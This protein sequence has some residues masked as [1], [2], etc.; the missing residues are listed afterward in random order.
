MIRQEI[1]DYPV[2]FTAFLQ[3]HISYRK[4]ALIEEKLKRRTRYLTVV[5][6]DIHKSHN[7]SA[8]LRTSECFGIQDLHIIEKEHAYNLHP[9]ISSGS[10]RWLDL[11]HYNQPGTNNTEV[12]LSG[13]KAQGYR[14]LV[15]TL[16]DQA[17]PFDEIEIDCKSA[18]VFGTEYSGVSDEA[19][20]MADEVIHIPMVGFTE[21]LNL[22]VSAGIILQ[23]YRR[24]LDNLKLPW[25]LSEKE[26]E[27]I[28]LNWTM[29]AVRKIDLHIKH[30]LEEK[31]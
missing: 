11:H 30:F 7:A 27:S 5:L 29:N 20:A 17:R 12:C 15:T 3:S 16:N 25:Q 31:A 1:Y 14:V 21:S 26:T 18:V 9:H 8:V 24:L 13:L 19:I 2:E 28:R 10:A 4:R 6:E 23:H 22:S